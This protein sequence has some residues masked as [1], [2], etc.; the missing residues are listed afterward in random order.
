[1]TRP[2]LP[3]VF[4]AL[5]FG[6]VAMS[7]LAWT[8]L[9]WPDPIVDFGQQLYAAWQVSEGAVLYR[10]LAY[11]HGP[12]SVHVNAAAMALLGDSLITLVGLNLFVLVLTLV[13]IRRIA[14]WLGGLW[15]AAAAGVVFL[16]VFAFARYLPTGNY[17]WVTPYTHE[18]TH[19]LALALAALFVL[20]T[21]QRQ[22]DAWLAGVLAGLVL[23]T[24]LE[25]AVALVATFGVLLVLERR[26]WSRVVGGVVGVLGVAWVGLAIRLGPVDAWL[27]IVTPYRAPFLA[28]AE[29]FPLYRRMLGLDD[30]VTTV[31]HLGR[32][33]I[34]WLIAGAMVVALGFLFR[35]RTKIGI[36]AAVPLVGLVAFVG[37][38]PWLQLARPLPV[39]VIAAAG[40]WLWRWRHE[41]AKEA[42]DPT[43]ARRQ[44]FRH[45]RIVL[46][47]GLCLFATFLLAKI[48]ATRVYHV[49]FALA[50]PAALVLVVAALAWLPR[51][52]A[53]RGG[54]ALVA[55]TAATALLI[56]ALWGHLHAMSGPIDAQT[57]AVGVQASDIFWADQRGPVVQATLEAIE[58]R[59]EADDT[60][61]IVPDGIMLAYLSRRRIAGPYLNYVPT[62]VLAFGE[63]RMLEDLVA[64]PPDH[65]VVVRKSTRE[66]GYEGFG[67]DYGLLLS[68][69]ID[70]HYQPVGRVGDGDVLLLSRR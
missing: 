54:D 23:L 50:L 36:A 49:G 58:T 6:A 2:S 31:L 34:W 64:D 3:R 22:R 29:S 45:R 37:G 20:T 4:V 10:D 70:Q 60:L 41:P 39:L 9:T 63:T 24:K 1:M 26:W 30:P 59:T 5:L 65:V 57:R 61:L 27:G 35:G 66:F 11:F 53:G 68:T 56:V 14:E 48:L 13:L 19:G 44:A 38:V 16:I 18:I 32:A 67:I 46:A 42:S 21:A 69:W 8:W 47:A 33:S 25:V 17:N 52:I 43:E 40:Y 51:W 12:L 55:R 28:G 15:V 62:E 7:M